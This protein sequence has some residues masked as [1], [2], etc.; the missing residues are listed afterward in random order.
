M[1]QGHLDKDGIIG[2]SLLEIKRLVEGASVK[3]DT[4]DT[5][6]MRRSQRAR[7]GRSSA[8]RSSQSRREQ[9]EPP[10]ENM[11]SGNNRVVFR[12]L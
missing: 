11:F 1:A 5:K 12:K 7:G 4:K 3:P 10:Q 8:S 2:K 9:P 6:N